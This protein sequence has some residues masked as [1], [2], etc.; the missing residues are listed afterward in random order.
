MADLFLTW[1]EAQGEQLPHY[2]VSCAQPATEWADWRICHSRHRVFS[3]EYTHIDVTLPVCPRHR[4]LNW[5]FLHR[6]V[7]RKVDAEGVL[8]SHVSPGFVEAVWDYREQM[9]RGSD[10][11][12]SHGFS[13]AGSWGPD[14]EEESYESYEPNLLPRRQYGQDRFV[15]S[16]P[17]WSAA[18]IFLIVL[19]ALFFAPFVL[20][21]MCGLLAL[22]L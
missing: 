12:P 13:P 18:K 2:C 1:E 19:A 21:M 5:F 22:L 11:G 7:A 8:L 15:P 17:I 16:P 4:N 9:E 6:V 14:F 20:L 3:I 10:V